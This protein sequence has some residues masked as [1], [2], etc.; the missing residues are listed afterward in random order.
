MAKNKWFKL[1]TS[2]IKLVYNRQEYET[3]LNFFLDILQ[4]S[5]KEGKIGFLPNYSQVE[6]VTYVLD[7]TPEERKELTE[8][9]LRLLHNSKLKDNL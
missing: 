3:C 8:A 5:E 6:D 2:K 4:Q 7:I 1:L 9:V